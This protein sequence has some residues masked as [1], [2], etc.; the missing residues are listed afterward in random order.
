MK[1]TKLNQK[2]INLNP[3]DDGYTKTATQ[4]E[5]YHFTYLD[6]NNSLASV[7]IDHNPAFS[8]CEIRS[9]ANGSD[10]PTIEIIYPSGNKRVIHADSA[11]D[12]IK[13]LRTPTYED[14]RDA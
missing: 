7:I 11:E 12:V 2:G 14:V 1:L 6:L 13:E 9:I 8:D 10:F 5:P 4:R 3:T